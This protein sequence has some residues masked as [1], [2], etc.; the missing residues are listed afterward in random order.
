[1]NTMII[2]LKS[3]LEI[4]IIKTTDGVINYFYFEETWKNIYKIL[5]I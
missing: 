3:K 4:I 1:M 5:K 2:N